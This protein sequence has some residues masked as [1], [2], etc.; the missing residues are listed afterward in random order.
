M[1]AGPREIPVSPRPATRAV[2]VVAAAAALIRAVTRRHAFTRLQAS[3]RARVVIV[4][5]VGGGG[6]N[7][8]TAKRRLSRE[9][10]VSARSKLINAPDQRAA[11]ESGSRRPSNI[12]AKDIDI[13]VLY[14]RHDDGILETR[15]TDKQISAAGAGD[16]F[17]G[18][19]FVPGYFL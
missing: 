5:V 9:G 2:H 8:E 4:V 13:A 17:H 14:T 7:G 11:G 6:D 3:T 15:N 19:F 18:R 16:Q 1:T 12:D 10:S